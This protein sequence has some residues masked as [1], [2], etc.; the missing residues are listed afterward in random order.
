MQKVTYV[1][2]R[3]Q[4]QFALNVLEPGE[5]EA[6]RIMGVP[7]RCSSCGSHDVVKPENL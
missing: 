5:A 6:R 1:C 3:C 2:L 7:P 4:S